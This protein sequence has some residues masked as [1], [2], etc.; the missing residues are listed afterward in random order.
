MSHLP[1]VEDVSIV[2][3]HGDLQKTGEFE[4]SNPL[5]NELH[6]IGLRTHL[7]YIHNYPNDPTREKAGWS[8]DIQNMFESANYMTNAAMMY[9]QWWQDF[10][11]TQR[12]DGNVAS[13]APVNVD[14]VEIW[15][16]PW[17]GGA[18]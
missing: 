7:N 14:F 13:V 6:E 8:Q 12:K 2:S 5:F 18:Q 16:D 3:V 4:C 1:K 9:E 15:N 17:W 10:A 11:D